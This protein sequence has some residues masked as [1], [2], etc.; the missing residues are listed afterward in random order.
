[1]V[2]DE[3][4]FP[5]PPIIDEDDTVDDNIEVDYGQ[6]DEGEFINT[7][8]SDGLDYTNVDSDNDSPD[9]SDDDLYLDPVGTP[10]SDLNM[11]LPGFEDEYTTPSSENN[12]GFDQ[13]GPSPVQAKAS[14]NNSSARREM[15]VTAACTSSEENALR[16]HHGPGGPRTNVIFNDHPSRCSARN[17]T[18]RISVPVIYDPDRS[19]HAARAP[20]LTLK[21]RIL[22][23]HASLS[24]SHL[25]NS[26]RLPGFTRALP[27]QRT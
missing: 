9:Y 12:D 6:P 14:R 24:S 2:E 20:H 18:A 25:L 3:E 1:M 13:P 15:V 16:E 4:N 11:P 7:I 21:E 23:L 10:D 19:A 17:R 27:Q 22:A 5:E 8:G 26:L